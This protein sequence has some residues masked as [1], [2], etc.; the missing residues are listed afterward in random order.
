METELFYSIQ[1]GPIWDW[2]VAIDLFLGGV[3]VGALLFAIL[4]D[5]GFRGKHHRITHTGAWMSPI[6]VAAGL[7]FIMLEMGR[8]FSAYHTYLNVNLA[9]PLWWG[10]ICQPLVVIGGFVYAYLCNK[11]KAHKTMRR[12]I[13]WCLIPLTI[14]VGAYHGMLLAVLV[15]RPLWNVGPT[16]IASLLGFLSS[17][18]AMVILVHL[19]RMKIA[20]RLNDPDHL[21]TFLND[22]VP[23][24][25]TLGSLL[26]LKLGTFFLWW[27]SLRMGSLQAQQALE[28]ANASHG[29]LFWGGGIGIGLILPILLG[30][31]LILQP[32]ARQEKI[33][34]SVIAWSSA[35]IVLGVF[36][37][38]LAL[39]LA[40]QAPLPLNLAL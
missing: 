22:I 17:G 18:V 27:I 29:S 30:A 25:Y 39:V 24:R 16:V 2:K 21:H 36:C 5:E 40:G 12:R 11:P 31:Y 1:Q 4:L 13:G 8:P 10:G 14:I 34:V 32:S 6:L 38:R 20:G 28:S 3:G 7:A 37:F 26:F 15:A 35:M 33:E 23:V 19:L 9:S